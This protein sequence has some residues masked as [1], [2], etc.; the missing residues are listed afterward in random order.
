MKNLIILCVVGLFFGLFSVAQAGE[1]LSLTKK[2][3]ESLSK[4][5]KTFIEAK[6]KYE[7]G[8]EFEAKQALA[9]SIKDLESKYGV[10]DLLKLSDLWYRIREGTIDSSDRIFK[11]N[12]KGFQRGEFVDTTEMDQRKYI[13]YLSLPKEYDPE[14]DARFPVIL[15]LHPEIPDNKKADKETLKLLET[16]YGDEDLLSRYIIIAPIGPEIVERKKKELKDAGKDWESLEYGRKTAFAAIRILMEQMVFDRSKVILDGAGTAGLSTYKYATWYPSFFAGAVG[17][18]AVV[19]SLAMEN[20]KNIPF[21]YVSSAGNPNKEAAVKWVGGLK[22][23]SSIEV[24]FVDDAGTAEEPSTDAVAA[25][26]EWMGKINKD[27]VPKEIYLK[28]SDLAVAGAHWL[29]ID[30][31]NAGLNM[32][33]DDPKYPWI[34]G[35]VDADSNSIVI[36]SSNVLQARI[37]LSD[38]LVDLDKKVTVILNG[39]KRFE[40]KIERSLDK[41]LE[42]IYYNPAGD[43]EIYCNSIELA[44]E[45]N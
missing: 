4:T 38:K 36:E 28:T 16:L 14:G 8:D 22:E 41:M 11:K 10:A 42:L 37:F 18:D 20:V 5:M 29:R 26:K 7:R 15:F 34:K 6:I 21:L 35:T 27:T 32:K 13:Y 44:E 24:A 31:L 23:A 1:D 9:Q 39:N 3:L 17:R 2:E 45:L 33:L 43:F 30:N 40:G 25:I 19:E 12:G